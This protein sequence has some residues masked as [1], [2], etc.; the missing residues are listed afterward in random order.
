MLPMFKSCSKEERQA[1]YDQYRKKGLFFG[2]EISP[3]SRAKCKGC[4]KTISV[5][6]VRFRHI[7]CSSA[8]CC[9]GGD[10]CGRWHTTCFRSA[11]TA[12]PAIFVHTNAEW[13]PVTSLAQ[14]AGVDLLPEVHRE[15]LIAE[16]EAKHG[17]RVATGDAHKK[18]RTR[19]V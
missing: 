4:K 2:A 9:R 17:K 3:S 12:T 7:V 1:K 13:V 18:K 14:I 6:D 15:R 19:V 11:Q 10:S 16:F 8:V 5:G